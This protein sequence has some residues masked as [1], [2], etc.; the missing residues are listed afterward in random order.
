M[1]FLFVHYLG[2]TLPKPVRREAIDMQVESEGLESV[3]V[4]LRDLH[5]RKCGPTCEHVPGPLAAKVAG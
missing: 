1:T 3:Y 4:R 2:D 5:L